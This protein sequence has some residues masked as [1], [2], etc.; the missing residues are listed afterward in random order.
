MTFDGQLTLIIVGLMLAAPIFEL[1]EPDAVLFTA[2][3]ALLLAGVITPTEALAGFANRGMLTVALLFIVAY[4][5]QS[6]GALEFFADRVMGGG[7]GLRRRA[8]LRMM[9]PVSLLSAFLNNTPIVAMFAPAVA[10][11]ARRHHLSPSKYLIPL[12]YAAILGGACTLI[13]TS[14][15]LLVNGMMIE[16]GGR[17]LGLFEL[18]LVGVPCTIV[19]LIYILTIGYSILPDRQK[20]PDIANNQDYHFEMR[21]LEDAPIIGRNIV[22]AG[23]RHL[24]HLYLS[25]IVRGDKVVAP[26]KPDEILVAGDR[27]CFV[28][29]PDGISHLRRI[30]GLVPIEEK[31]WVSS[32]HDTHNGIIEAVVSH[33]SPMLGKTIKEGNFRSRYDAAVL[34]VRRHGERIQRGI[35]GITLK[36][37]DTLLLL[38][39]GD[40]KTRWGGSR[41]FYLINKVSE[42][43]F[44][45]NRKSL[46]AFGAM[47]IMVLLAAFG[48]MDIFKAATLAVLVLLISR[49]VSVVE[50]RRSMELNVLIVIAAALGISQALTKSGAALYLAS[51][52][53]E[54]VS[55]WGALGLLAAIYLATTIMTEVITNN[56]AA[57]LMFPIAWSAALKG[58][59]EPLP[60]AIAVAVAA[61]TSFATPIG[62]Q[63]NLMVYG[64]GNYRFTDFLKIGLPLNLLVLTTAITA[65]YVSWLL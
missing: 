3:G 22:K 37:G 20:A 58:G 46:I 23:L 34:A 55:G 17:S 48:I 43:P 29:I 39:G 24:N 53:L 33:S 27:L 25:E 59:Y 40:F 7:K 47:I 49:S 21:V 32:H 56:A 57:A 8:L 9:I 14:T 18:A 13:G 10:E 2:L 16:A 1:L 15:N 65:I 36:P 6:S 11:W 28:G 31:N 54:L 19:G 45:D 62:Y 52:L 42:F 63:T 61:S 64:L 30:S 38:A 5:I 4:G 35:G 60:F 51:N 41:D 26:V 50:A 12:S 44:V